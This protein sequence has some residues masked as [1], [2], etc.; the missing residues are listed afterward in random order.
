MSSLHSSSG[1]GN[2]MDTSWNMKK[3][4]KN[5]K[6]KHQHIGA[7]KLEWNQ[8]GNLSSVCTFFWND[9]TW[10]THVESRSLIPHD[11]EQMMLSSTSLI[12]HIKNLA[13]LFFP[14]EKIGE[15]NILCL[16]KRCRKKERKGHTHETV[17]CGKHFHDLTS[18]NDL[19][20]RKRRRRHSSVRLGHLR[21]LLDLN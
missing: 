19:Q 10:W 14:E 17:L 5:P 1:N 15:R 18:R 13:V 3:K 21:L 12:F 7:R 16:W 20:Q 4:K 6:T 2:S 8:S 9:S 11:G